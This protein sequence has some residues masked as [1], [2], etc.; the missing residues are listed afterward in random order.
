[1]VCLFSGEG[2]VLPTPF[3]AVKSARDHAMRRPAKSST[4]AVRQSRH[5]IW[6]QTLSVQVLEPPHIYEL[7]VITD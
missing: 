2:V 3:V 4:T 7:M 6:N 1:V 5:P